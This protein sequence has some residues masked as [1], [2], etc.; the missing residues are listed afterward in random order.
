LR[1]SFRQG[2]GV[3]QVGY[4]EFEQ[5]RLRRRTREQIY[6]ELL[7]CFG[8]M[9]AEIEMF[10]NCDLGASGFETS[11]LALAT[12]LAATLE[13][14]HGMADTLVSEV[15]NDRVYRAVAHDKA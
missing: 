10:G 15:L 9:V 14:V 7:I 13:A 1:D 11:D 3:L 5:P 2:D 8:G 12:D 4:V 6:S